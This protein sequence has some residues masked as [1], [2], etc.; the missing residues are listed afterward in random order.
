MINHSAQARAILT[1]KWVN[2]GTARE[3]GWRNRGPWSPVHRLKMM[4]ALY[5]LNAMSPALRRIHRVERRSRWLTNCIVDHGDRKTFDLAGIDPMTGRKFA[6]HLEMPL[7]ATLCDFLM[8]VMRCED[9]PVIMRLDA[10]KNAAVLTHVKPK[11]VITVVEYERRLQ[12]RRERHR[13]TARRSYARLKA[14]KA[15]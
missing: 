9:A 5:A 3:M 14:A 2:I 8:L 11:P 12:R 1:T 13:E 6:V 4:A 15:R 7:D 10:A